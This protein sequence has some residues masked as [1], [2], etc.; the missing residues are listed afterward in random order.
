MVP[1]FSLSNHFSDQSI[2]TPAQRQFKYTVEATIRAL[3]EEKFGT[4]DFADCFVV[5]IVYSPE[6]KKLEVFVDSDTGILL[7]QCGSINR[8]L[9]GHLDETGVLG[10]KYVLDVSSPG[11]GAPLR[12]LRQYHKNIGR[13]L[14]VSLEN[15]KKEKGVL[16]SASNE[17]IRIAQQTKEK[18]GKK[19]VANN[20]V[21]EIPF[22]YIDKAAVKI[23]FG[24]LGTESIEDEVED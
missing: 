23:Q 1:S 4:P 17:A 6:R 16:L 15:G 13:L 10:E 14:E 11:V 9:Q 18:V 21:L 2:R 22:E 24:K 3:L 7:D 8:Y 5:D 12:L 20:T 19:K